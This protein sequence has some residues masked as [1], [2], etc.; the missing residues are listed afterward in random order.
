MEI[1][2]PDFVRKELKGIVA[3]RIEVT[4][5]EANYKLRQNRDDESYESIISHLEERQDDLSHDVAEAMKGN[6]GRTR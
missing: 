1:L 2:P 5:L 4:R 3:F 6:R